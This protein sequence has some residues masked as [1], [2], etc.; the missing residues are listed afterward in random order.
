VSLEDADV[1][2]LIDRY[3]FVVRKYVTLAKEL[4]PKLEKFGKHKKELEVLTVEFDRRGIQPK[5]S[6][7][8]KESILAEINKRTP[9][10][11]NQPEGYSPAEQNPREA[12]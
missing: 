3:E 10:D 6:E 8:L 11:E 9:S 12:D 1:L 5:D 2:E 7:E 4:A